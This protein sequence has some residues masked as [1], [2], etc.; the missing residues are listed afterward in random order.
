MA[1][2]L[3]TKIIAEGFHQYLKYNKFS[4]ALLKLKWP[5]FSD[6]LTWHNAIVVN[7]AV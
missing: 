6:D 1:F 7:K 5:Q 3:E 2:S 4:D